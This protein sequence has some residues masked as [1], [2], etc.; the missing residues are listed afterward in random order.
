MASFLVR[1]GSLATLGLALFRRTARRHDQYR[2]ATSKELGRKIASCGSLR[3][4]A[5]SRDKPGPSQ[6]RLTEERPK[7][8]CVILT[9]PDDTLFMEQRGSDA[10]IAAGRL[11]CFGGKVEAGES[12][13]SCIRRECREELG[14]EPT[15]PLRRAVDL[16]VDGE[17]IAWFYEAP[18]PQDVAS[19]RFEEGRTGVFWHNLASERISDWHSVVLNAW[20]KG[21]SR[22]D[23]IGQKTR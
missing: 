20:S 4:T 3:D 12:P 10:K 21:D 19:L 22:A 18:A 9:G 23:F 17:L 14:W 13:D 16:Y 5:A 6:Y 15:G 7:Y 1:L 8:C 2:T 11:T